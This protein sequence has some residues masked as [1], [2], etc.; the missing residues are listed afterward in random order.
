MQ[1]CYDLRHYVITTLGCLELIEEQNSDK[2][3]AE[4]A[5]KTA[6]KNTQAAAQTVEELYQEICR[7][8]KTLRTLSDQSSS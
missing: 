7:A 3:S 2:N 1:L 5:L 8:E 6:L 4:K